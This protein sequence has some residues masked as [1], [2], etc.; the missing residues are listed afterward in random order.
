[1]STMPLLNQILLALCE[2]SIW[3]KYF[4]EP[5]FGEVQQQFF[6]MLARARTSFATQLSTDLQ[7]GINNSGRVSSIQ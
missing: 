4:L 3:L 1:M 6:D 7:D 2:V 5:N